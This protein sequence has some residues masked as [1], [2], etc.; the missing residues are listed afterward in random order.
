MAFPLPTCQSFA[1][2][3]WFL[4]AQAGALNSLRFWYCFQ[5]QAGALH[6]LHCA[7]EAR[8]TSLHQKFLM[9]L[10]TPHKVL[11]TYASH[12][13]LLP[14][15]FEAGPK[16]LASAG[17]MP[18]FRDAN[19]VARRA[20]MLRVSP[21]NGRLESLLSEETES[22]TLTRSV[23]RVLTSSVSLYSFTC[24]TIRQAAVRGP[25][26]EKGADTAVHLGT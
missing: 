11:L 10:N 9:L 17:A 13:A 19:T 12:P 14:C 18:T 3:L 8:C 5:A 22:N 15:A 1:I 26:L 2:F 7:H 25:Q 20:G 6:S 24:S 4:Q 21:R 23:T 16:A